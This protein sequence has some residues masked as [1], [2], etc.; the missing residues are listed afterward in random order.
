MIKREIF[1]VMGMHSSSTSITMNMLSE[2]GMYMGEK[3][4]IIGI[5]HKHPKGIYERRDVFA[6]NETILYENETMW[7]SIH[8]H[9]TYKTER[10]DEIRILL[11]SLL[12]TCGEHT[13][14]GIKDPR[15]CLLE[16]LWREEISKIEGCEEH[17][18]IVFRHPYETAVSIEKKNS[19]NYEYALKLWF[20]YNFFIIKNAYSFNGGNCLVIRNS[21][22]YNDSKNVFSKLSAIMGVENGHEICENVIDPSLNHYNYKNIQCHDSRLNNMV[23]DMYKTMVNWSK[24][25][26]LEKAKIDYF[27]KFVEEMVDTSYVENN[28][29]IVFQAISNF[30]PVVVLKRWCSFQLTYNKEDCMKCLQILGKKYSKFYI[31]GNGTLAQLLLSIM[32][33]IKLNVIGVFDIVN[34]DNINNGY[35]KIIKVCPFEK[36]KIENGSYIINTVVDQHAEIK[37]QLL[38]AFSEDKI[39]SLFEIFYMFFIELH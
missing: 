15:F 35:G 8:K 3:N 30:K 37:D 18:I 19:I 23:I 4:G 17:L 9:K 29:D 14:I 7:F 2:L 25:G 26:K 11:Q 31:Y 12:E 36:S 22:Y 34:T 21:D 33:K 20:Y 6:L 32:F 27:E 28:T 16:P 1:I 38:S 24:T 39:I 5:T 10:R 13:K